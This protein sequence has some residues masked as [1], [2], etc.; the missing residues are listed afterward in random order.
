MDQPRPAHESVVHLGDDGVMTRSTNEPAFW[1][2]A[3]R[4]E[5][6][7]GSI[8]SVFS[9]SDTWDYQERHDVGDELALVLDGSIE[10]LI[11]TGR[12]EQPVRVARGEVSVIPRGAWHRIAVHEPATI[13]FVTPQPASTLHRTLSGPHQS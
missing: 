4:C 10:L 7:S 3:G 12:G 6:S 8:L 11:D 13:L 2:E 1:S 9:Y 5:L